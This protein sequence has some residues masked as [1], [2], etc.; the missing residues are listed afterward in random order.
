M[1]NQELTEIRD[2]IKED[3]IPHILKRCAL[4]RE[5]YIAQRNKFHRTV[6]SVCARVDIDEI[7]E[8]ILRRMS[9]AK[10]ME[11]YGITEEPLKRHWQYHLRPLIF[12]PFAP[13]DGP[14]LSSRIASMV[15]RRSMATLPIGDHKR[16]LHF[17]LLDII[18]A[19]RLCFGNI[20][21]DGLVLEGPNVNGIITTAKTMV[22]I[23]EKLKALEESGYKSPNKKMRDGEEESYIPADLVPQEQQTLIDEGLRKT[24]EAINAA[25]NGADS[26]EDFSHPARRRSPDDS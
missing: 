19:R 9:F 13:T 24:Q 22:A 18:L 6:C 10:L 1:R 23:S 21:D 14:A 26:G 7:N 17:A 5:K 3:Q 2:S 12:T 8:N 15:K 20:S 25:T 4:E 11:V 16:M